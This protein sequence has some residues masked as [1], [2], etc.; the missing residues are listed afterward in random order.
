MRFLFSGLFLFTSCSMKQFYPTAGAIVGGGVGSIAGPAA[1][2][3]GAGGGALLG[4]VARGNAEI[5]ETKEK[6]EALTHGDVSALVEAGLS[7]HKSGFESFT[8]SIKKILVV[9]AAILMIYLAIPILV[10]KKC[11]QT[12]AIKATRAPF[13]PSRP[14]Y[15]RRKDR[16]YEKPENT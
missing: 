5:Q 11:S 4:E 9:A 8:A 7:E 14:S 15:P 16:D 2:A 10:A 3:V 12:E 1:G 6:L 13:M